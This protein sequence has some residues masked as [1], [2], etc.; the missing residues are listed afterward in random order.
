MIRIL[1]QSN[2]IKNKEKLVSGRDRSN[3]PDTFPRL[4]PHVPARGSKLSRTFSGNFSWLRAGVWKENFP[5]CPKLWPLFLR[6]LQI[7]MPGSVLTPCSV[8]VFRL[9]FLV[10]I[11]YFALPS[12]VLEWI[13]VVPVVRDSPQ[14]HT[15]QIVEIIEKSPQ[16]WVGMAPEGSRKYPEKSAVVLSYC[17]SGAFADCDVFL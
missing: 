9:R 15:R 7:L 8:S 10:K 11:A 17:Q 5:I 14:G 2:I 3:D 12:P 4:P 16:I 13:G 1:Q 6:I